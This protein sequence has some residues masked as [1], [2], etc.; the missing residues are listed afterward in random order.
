MPV[1][2]RRLQRLLPAALILAIAGPA[3]S[4]AGGTTAGSQAFTAGAPGAFDPRVSDGT[5]K[6]CGVNW[7]AGDSVTGADLDALVRDHVT[8]IAQ[9]PFGW[10]NGVGNPEVRLVTEG[11]V[12]WGERDSGLAQTTRMAHERG[13]HVMLKPHLW[14]RGA[15]TG[16]PESIAMADEAGWDAWFASYRAFILHYAAFAEAHGI[17]ALCIGTELG[18][19]LPG[20][21]TQ[22]REIIRAVRGVY[23][24]RLTYAANWYGEWEK[25]PFWDALDEVGIQAYFPLCDAPR[26]GLDSL[27]AGWRPHL[28][29]IEAFQ[30]RT[31]KPVVFTEIGYRSIPAAGARPW[32]WPDRRVAAE[33]DSVAQA[34]CYEAFFRAVWAKPWF[35]GAYVWKWFPHPG[36]WSERADGFTPQGKPAEGVMALWY[37]AT[38]ASTEAAGPA[39]N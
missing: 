5:L 3:C 32:E 13:I 39:G 28:A 23:P 37:G 33:A 6:Q 38:G 17:E 26:A 12:L 16:G 34:R 9:T 35:A 29:R 2:I 4:G 19:T 36:R 15:G 14:V 24:G 22:W 27:R 31:G 20:H 8:W 25:V 7:V 30:K 21:E 10:Q 1:R 11:R 18:S